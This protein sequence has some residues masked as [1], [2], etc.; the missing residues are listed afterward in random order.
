MQLNPETNLKVRALLYVIGCGGLIHLTTLLV[1]AITKGQASYF[2]PLN[3]VDIDQL[4]EGS[5]HSVI[6]FVGGW[7]IFGLMVH[8]V[9]RVLKNRNGGK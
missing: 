7:I 2:N 1:I 5:R 9:Y 8:I 4:W 3:A 6:A